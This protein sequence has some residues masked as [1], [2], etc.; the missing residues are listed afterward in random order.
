MSKTIPPEVAPG[1]VPSERFAQNGDV[2]SPSAL[3]RVA[4]VYNQISTSYRK[5][6]FSIAHA[7]QS[8]PTMP[9][10]P[11]T[12]KYFAF[13]TGENV[14]AV[15]VLL[16]LA[17][18]SSA[19]G[20]NTARAFLTLDDNISTLTSASLHYPKVQAGTFTP[21][22]VAWVRTEITVADGL[23]ANTQYSGAI[24]QEHYSRIAAV[25]VYEEGKEIADSTDDGT[26][27]PLAYQ[28]SAP[29]Y[30]D[31]I[32]D[33][34]ETGTLLWRHNA[35]QLLSWSRHTEATATV[36]EVT[37]TSYVNL[38]DGSSTDAASASSPG[39]RIN[40]QYHDTVSG[41]VPV[42]LGVRVRR[43]AGTGTMDIQLI[44]ED[45]SVLLSTTISGSAASPYDS[46][47]HTITA[48]AALKVDIQTRV[49]DGAT[50][51]EVDCVG[52]WEYEA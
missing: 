48:A 21:A 38:L 6:L 7:T 20:A 19:N 3:R 2:P 40:T 51:Y 18:A 1:P 22:E 29:I 11:Q 45:N 32:Q 33:L 44:L 5:T 4:H 8:T 47:T 15:V 31:T 25:L 23:L 41:D 35:C 42:E 27:D 37:S 24:T 39:M 28:Q 36:L 14:R 9:T 52:L 17:P 16:G 12:D 34:C 13:R 49:S 43:T 26:T 46:S 10:T 30:A 50:T